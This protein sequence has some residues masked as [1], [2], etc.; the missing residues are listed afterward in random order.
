[1]QRALAS[2]SAA[3]RPAPATRPARRVAR[4]VVS[5][6][7]NKEQVW[8]ARAWRGARGGQG[9][10]AEKGGQCQKKKKG[11]DG[12]ARGGGD[13]GPATRPRRPGPIRVPRAPHQ[14]VNHSA[15]PP[16]ADSA[17]DGRVV[18]AARGSPPLP[19]LTLLGGEG[20]RVAPAASPRP[21]K[22]GGAR[23]VAPPHRP[24]QA[25]ERTPAMPLAGSRGADAATAGPEAG[26]KA[27][28]GGSIRRCRCH[29]R[30]LASQPLALALNLLPPRPS[31]PLHPPHRSS[32]P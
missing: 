3:L 12:Q 8:W 19:R 32:P 4:V 30:L 16:P 22:R 1:M 11:R 28:E 21:A 5:A 18:R 2:R 23:P 27:S 9:R 31:P 24:T 26:A 10:E 20:P 14:A 17:V 25:G 7:A 15:N 13:P 29:P 6:A